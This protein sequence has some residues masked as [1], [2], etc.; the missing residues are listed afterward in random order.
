MEG[1]CPGGNL[2]QPHWKFV[3]G[4]EQVFRKKLPQLFCKC[5]AKRAPMSALFELDKC[6]IGGRF[7]R[8][9]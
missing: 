3:C 9:D 5:S 6:R 2:I 4:E 8:S 7:E 1:A